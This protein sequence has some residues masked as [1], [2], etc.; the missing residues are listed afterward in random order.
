MAEAKSIHPRTRM[1][2]RATGQYH[3]AMLKWK[4]KFKIIVSFPARLESLLA[5]LYT[6]IRAVKENIY[7]PM[8]ATF[9]LTKLPVER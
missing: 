9:G 8:K 6:Y 4:T 3:L 7:R 1:A 5:A 2:C